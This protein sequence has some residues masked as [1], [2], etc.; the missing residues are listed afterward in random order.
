MSMRFLIDASAEPF[1]TTSFPQALS[2]FFTMFLGPAL[3]VEI[4]IMAFCAVCLTGFFKWKR[5]VVLTHFIYFVGLCIITF[6][7]TMLGYATAGSIVMPPGIMAP[8]I[9]L[10]ILAPGAIFLAIFSRGNPWHRAL[11]ITFYL[12]LCYLVTEVSHN[13]NLIID[14]FVAR[15]SAL[16]SFL[17]CLPFLILIPAFLFA[18]RLR[19]H[20]VAHFRKT[21]ALQYLFVFLVVLATAFLSGFGTGDDIVFRVWTII[22]LILL[23]VVDLFAYAS[24]YYTSK[25][26]RTI[27]A[28]QARNQLNE[29]ASVMLKLSE[30]DIARN[31]RARHDLKN[32]LSYLR[33]AI[34]QGRYEDALTF[35]DATAGKAYGDLQLVDCGN[36]V[37][38]SIMNLELRK[39]KLSHVEIRYRL[40]VP[41]RLGISDNDLCSLLTN[42]LDNAIEGT[43]ACQEQGYID[44]SLVASDALLRIQCKNP[45]QSKV[46]PSHSTKTE[47]GHGHGTTIIKAIVKEY[48]GYYEFDVKD[49]TFCLDCVMNVN[50]KQEDEDA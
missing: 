24:H 22:V 42:I 19:I 49:G 32:T 33:E 45:T 26:E 23:G 3:I 10:F 27:A 6:G 12:S 50:P 21:L 17:F 43:C 4:M 14:E 13:Y 9:I 34:E 40:I 39:A 1:P 31:T 5:K 7:T 8:I 47:E 29:A 36:A 15:G 48:G 35:I 41:P 25:R 37:V 11:R 44:F 30:E 20:H 46:V 38:S 2:N 28:L 16:A 18:G